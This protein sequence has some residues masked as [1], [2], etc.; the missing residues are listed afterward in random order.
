MAGPADTYSTDILLDPRWLRDRDVLARLVPHFRDKMIAEHQITLALRDGM[1]CLNC[2]FDPA[3]G[4]WMRWRVPS[5]YWQPPLE[6]T[7]VVRNRWRPP[8]DETAA[9]FPGLEW[10]LRHGFGWRG[11]MLFFWLPFLEQRWPTVFAP[12]PVKEITASVSALV[13]T[14]AS[15]PP[16]SESRPFPKSIAKEMAGRWQMI[17]AGL[18]LWREFPPD[19]KTPRMMSVQRCTDRLS[20]AGHWKA[21]NEAFGLTDPSP[22]VVGEAMNLLGRTND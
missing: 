15:N 8:P 12:A 16:A 2:W 11:S 21:E 5:L 10:A 14:A 1:D 9:I 7:E 4:A 19:G 22:D 6:W 20:D 3:A 13:A 18:A 17:R